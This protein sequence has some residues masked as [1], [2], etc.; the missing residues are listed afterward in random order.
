MKLSKELIVAI[1]L[2]VAA[3]TTMT[4]EAHDYKSFDPRIVG[5]RPAPEQLPDVAKS[6]RVFHENWRPKVAT[7]R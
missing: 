2:S 3:L 6:Y 7:I 4:A 5:L 1:T